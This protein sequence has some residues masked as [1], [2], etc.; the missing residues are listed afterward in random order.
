MSVTNT[1][2]VVVGRG[3][4]G[5]G[6]AERAMRW[7][8]QVVGPWLRS[9]AAGRGEGDEWHAGVAH[10]GAQ[11]VQLCLVNNSAAQG[12]GDVV[13]VC[14]GESVEPAGPVQVKRPADAE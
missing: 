1:T 14:E 10:L 4:P 7:S 9:G 2:P 5:P 3:R 11:S 6:V 13:V 12:G 8:A